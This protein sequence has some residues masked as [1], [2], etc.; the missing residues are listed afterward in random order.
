M[1]G[2]GNGGCVGSEGGCNLA[3]SVGWHRH[4]IT[5][6]LGSREI[7]IADSTLHAW[8]LHH[9]T[10]MRFL[11]KVGVQCWAE[12]PSISDQRFQAQ[13]VGLN[14][15]RE[16]VVRCIMGGCLGCLFGNIGWR[17]GGIMTVSSRTH[18][19]SLGEPWMS[20]GELRMVV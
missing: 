19:C 4:Q 14:G 16:M 2:F 20:L 18:A 11:R 13:R 7:Q 6:Q 1:H 15:Q 3:V 9:R 5:Y 17:F 8:Q 10:A 12:K